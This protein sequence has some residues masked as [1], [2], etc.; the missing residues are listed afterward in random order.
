MDSSGNV[1][2]TDESN[3]SVQKFTTSGQFLTKWGLEIEGGDSEFISPQGIAV[4]RS[5]SVYVTVGSC[6]EIGDMAD[7]V[8]GY[9]RGSGF[10]PRSPSDYSE[11]SSQ[12]PERLNPLLE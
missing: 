11:T 12:L 10:R 6:T 9:S 3:N 2:V 4:G 7:L 5:G 1:Y 8:A